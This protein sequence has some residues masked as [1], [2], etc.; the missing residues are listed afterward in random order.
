MRDPALE[1]NKCQAIDVTVPGRTQKKRA[2]PEGSAHA[3]RKETNAETVT[4]SRARAGQADWR[5]FRARRASTVA[6]ISSISGLA[7][8]SERPIN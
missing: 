4:P 5:W 7:M 8:P 1:I 6:T 2:E 3:R